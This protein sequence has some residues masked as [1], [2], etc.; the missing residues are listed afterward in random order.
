MEIIDEH[1]LK[2]GQERVQW[3]SEENVYIRAGGG[4]SSKKAG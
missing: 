1:H 3:T 4:W 2:T